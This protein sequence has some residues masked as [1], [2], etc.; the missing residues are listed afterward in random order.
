MDDKAIMGMET[1][2]LLVSKDADLLGGIGKG[3]NIT[4]L[5]DIDD[6]DSDFFRGREPEWYAQLP[7]RPG[8]SIQQRGLNCQYHQPC[9]HY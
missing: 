3:I 5:E 7:P 6:E 1:A 9:W 8:L 2:K 4:H